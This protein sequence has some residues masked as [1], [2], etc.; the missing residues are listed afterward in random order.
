MF[1]CGAWKHEYSERVRSLGG[2]NM[3][4][5]NV[6]KVL[7]GKRGGA[8]SKHNKH[9]RFRMSEEFG[10]ASIGRSVL[11]VHEMYH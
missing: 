4:N 3:A 6:Q 9:G 2:V 10:I 1:Y 8:V 11:G 5:N 7:Y